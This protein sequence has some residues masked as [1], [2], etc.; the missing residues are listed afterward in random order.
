[1][2]L[3]VLNARVEHSSNNPDAV[4]AIW[5]LLIPR[6]VSRLRSLHVLRVK[7][8][9]SLL[10]KTSQGRSHVRVNRGGG[11]GKKKKLQNHIER[12]DLVLDAL[13]RSKVI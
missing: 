3:H 9:V 13:P 1:M 2:I 11:F 6:P 4:V 10:N 5:R 8:V 7:L 12:N